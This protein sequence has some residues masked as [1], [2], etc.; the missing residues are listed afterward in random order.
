MLNINMNELGLRWLVKTM[1]SF[2]CGIALLLVVLLL[3]TGG[4]VLARW[5]PFITA[6]E[7][8]KAG[9]SHD[10]FESKMKAYIEDRNYN[11]MSSIRNGTVTVSLAED[12]GLHIKTWR[13]LVEIQDGVVISVGVTTG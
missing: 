4:G 9:D 11:Y 13:C 3:L 12:R 7:S 5:S 1:A 6:C 10:V 2:A 8:V